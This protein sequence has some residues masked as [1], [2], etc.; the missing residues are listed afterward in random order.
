MFALCVETRFV[1]NN[2]IT[3]VDVCVKRSARKGARRALRQPVTRALYC[4]TE[5]E[6]VCESI[7]FELEPF[8][9]ASRRRAV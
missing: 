1:P 4:A 3:R 7:G 6:P 8:Q 9:A 2:A 5:V